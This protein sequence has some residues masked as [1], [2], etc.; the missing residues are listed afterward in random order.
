MR[1]LK[2]L[3]RV[4]QQCEGSDCP[5]AFCPLEPSS[6]VQCP[7]L[8]LPV[9]EECGAVGAGPERGHKDDQRAGA[10]LL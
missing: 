6:V 8:G 2:L 9:Q 5:P 7:D 3:Q 4:G 1:T 10:P